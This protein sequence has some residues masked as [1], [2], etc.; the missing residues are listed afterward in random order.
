MMV[1][2]ITLG[3]ISLRFLD[4]LL[5]KRKKL[6]MLEEPFLKDPKAFLVHSPSS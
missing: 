2:E 1:D 3:Q 5:P 4:S 6:F